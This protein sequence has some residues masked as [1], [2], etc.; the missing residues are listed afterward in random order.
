VAREPIDKWTINNKTQHKPTKGLEKIITSY[1]LI[2]CWWSDHPKTQEF[3]YNKLA[4]LF[5][6][7]CWPYKNKAEPSLPN[8]LSHILRKIGRY[9]NKTDH[10]MLNQ[11][12]ITIQQ[13]MMNEMLVL[14]A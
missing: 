13:K 7:T 2:D 3:T 8:L 9:I 14:C 6:M 5:Q 1:Q 11:T 4:A 10:M 12:C